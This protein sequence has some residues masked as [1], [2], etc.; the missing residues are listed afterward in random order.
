M[1]PLQQTTEGKDKPNIVSDLRI[2]SMFTLAYVNQ[3]ICLSLGHIYP[4]LSIVCVF[5][6]VKTVAD[7][8]AYFLL[9]VKI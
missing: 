8:Y 6:H 4:V 7:I 5:D 9:D 1:S 3:N 2:N